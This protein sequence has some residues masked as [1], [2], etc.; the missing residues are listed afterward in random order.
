MAEPVQPTILWLTDRSRY[1]TGLDK[2]ARERYLSYHFGPTGYGIQK[3]AT[4][5]PLTTG[6][7][8]HEGIAEV[9][10]WCK[11]AEHGPV[12][13][14]I[15]REA[16]RTAIEK[17]NR[18]I[19]LRGI[20]NLDQG[21]RVETI[22]KEQ[23]YLIE[24]LIWAFCLT[25]LP[26]I[27]EQCRIIEVERE[28]VLVVG[29]TCGL[30]DTI[31]TIEDHEARGC[32]GIGFQSR[33]DFITEYL[34]RPGVYAYWELKT[35]GQPNEP[36]ETQWETKIQFAAGALGAERRLEVP[37]SEAYVVGLIKGRREGDTYNPETRKREG[38]LR[39]QSSLCYWY[40]RPGNPPLEPEDWQVSWNYV[41]DDG[42]NHTL[43]KTYTKAPIWEMPGIA[44]LQE[45][46]GAEFAAKA[47][48]HDLLAKNILLLGPLNIQAVLVHELV[49]EL[50]AEENR[51]KAIV[52]E[53]ADVLESC[54]YEWSRPEFQAALRRLVPR[55]WA[56]RRYGKR[57]ECQFVDHCFEHEG[58]QDPLMDGKFVPRR[59]HHDP[60]LRQVEARGLVPEEGWADDDEGG[61]D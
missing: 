18:V 31:G 11:A 26:Y 10:S 4:A 22:A 48:G 41:G 60:E 56:C 51:W 42:R 52:W 24:G 53:L 39:Q 2:C 14:S 38:A 55:S 44:Q 15:I 46:S 43:G 28:E 12:P 47:M 25:T 23:S 9:L 19:E 29:C 3:K 35:L 40:R 58:W 36:W 1:E 6:S 17:Y 8:V 37:I 27:L 61:T 13:D 16:C 33:P 5:I 34:A 21:E 49:E 50:V 45:G 7:Y 59:P 30:G 20:R 54:E 32:E 57:H